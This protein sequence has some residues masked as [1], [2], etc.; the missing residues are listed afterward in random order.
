MIDQKTR[1]ARCKKCKEEFSQAGFGEDGCFSQTTW[2]PNECPN[3]GADKCSIEYP[4]FSIPVYPSDLEEG[5]QPN[6]TP[7]LP[8]S[9]DNMPGLKKR[10]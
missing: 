5:Q 4:M 9:H 3:C 8:R 2:T 7:G 10:Y 6:S 1:L